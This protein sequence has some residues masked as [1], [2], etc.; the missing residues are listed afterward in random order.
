MSFENFQDWDCIDRC[1]VGLARATHQ[2]GSVIHQCRVGSL[3]CAA[4]LVGLALGV[5][6]F[7][8]LLRGC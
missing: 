8:L 5:F 3:A 4:V 7:F 6:F 2:C 1:N